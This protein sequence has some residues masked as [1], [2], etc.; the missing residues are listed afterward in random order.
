VWSPNWSQCVIR[1]QI[2]LSDGRA[3]VPRSK[4]IETMLVKDLIGRFRAILS[5]FTKSYLTDFGNFFAF[6]NNPVHIATEKSPINSYSRELKRL[7]YERCLSIFKDFVRP[8]SCGHKAK[9]DIKH[10]HDIY[11]KFIHPET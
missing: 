10:E 7:R 2:P 5:V 1:T 8:F 11:L 3:E 4:S 6:C 9:S